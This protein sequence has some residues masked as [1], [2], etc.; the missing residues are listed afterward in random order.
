[1]TFKIMA[2]VMAIGGC[3][4][5]LR[6]MFLGGSVLREWGIE[7]A[8]GPLI[9]CRRLGALYL[10]LAVVFFLGRN[11]PASDLRSALCLGIGGAS[12]LLAGL[13]LLELYARRVTTGIVVSAIVEL[14]L[15]AGFG[16]AWW[17][18]RS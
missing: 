4:L 6:F 13:G 7:A 18:G 12:A 1:M 14:V 8:D 16:W 9:I 2:H 5:G 11:T 15:A 3:I 10:A 17:A